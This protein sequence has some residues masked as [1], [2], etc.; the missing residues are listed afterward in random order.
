[1]RRRAG[2][3]PRPRALLRPASLAGVALGRRQFL[4]RVQVHER[5]GR[6]IERRAHA[7]HAR[8]P[9]ADLAFAGRE[10]VAQHRQHGCAQRHAGRMA[11]AAGH[12]IGQGRA[13]RPRRGDQA[14]GQ[15]RRQERRVARRHHQPFARRGGRQ[16]GGQARQRPLPGA[17]R[18]G[19]VGHHPAIAGVDVGIA[20]GAENQR[21]D[22]RGQAPR[23]VRHQ[24]LATQQD[25]SLVAALHARALAAGQD[26]AGHLL[27]VEN[28][29]GVNHR[30]SSSR[31][32][33]P[34]RPCCGRAV[35]SSCRPGRPRYP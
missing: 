7:S 18:I 15:I 29:R 13:R 21:P 3:G 24:R 16:A 14:V 30:C 1:A 10:V 20:V 26:Q 19:I 6:V 33:G 28:G 25:Q 17:Q 22:L 34:G 5:A 35:R 9:Q 23:H 4:G 31:L 12:R 8:L 27:P 2:A 11:L 32:C